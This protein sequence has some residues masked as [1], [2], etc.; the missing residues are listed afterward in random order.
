MALTARPGAESTGAD[1]LLAEV[2]ETRRWM[3]D[4]RFAGL[5]RLYS[6]RQVVEQRGAVATA[7]PVARDAAQRL[8]RRLRELF[9]QRRRSPPSGRTRPARPWP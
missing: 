5:R 4:D 7:Y 6:P 8:H 1:P 9:A 3:S 2:E